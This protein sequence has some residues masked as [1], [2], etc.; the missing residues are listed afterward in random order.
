MDENVRDAETRYLP[1]DWLDEIIPTPRADP[2]EFVM[3]NEA[4]GWHLRDPDEAEPFEAEDGW[5]T[6]LQPGQVVKFSANRVFG[7]FT[8]TVDGSGYVTDRQIPAEAN[9]FRLDHDTDTLASSLEEL[10]N[11]SG[12]MHDPLQPGEY[13]IDAYWWSDEEYPFRFDIVDG[14]G[15]LV[16]VEGG[17]A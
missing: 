7:D 3:F 5:C 12:W 14:N 13:D 9:C 4:I 8:L 15:C 17:A 11:G 10:V 16:A 1:A 2:N 6:P